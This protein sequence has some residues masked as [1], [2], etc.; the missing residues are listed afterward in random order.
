[1]KDGTEHCRI[2]F[3]YDIHRLSEQRKLMLGG[4][5]V[6]AQK[7]EVGHS[8]ADV[9]LHAIIDALLGAMSADDIGAHFPP[10]DNAWKNI[11]STVL[12]EHTV[13]LLKK[14]GYGCINIDATVLLEKPKLRPHIR[15]IRENIARVIGM[16]PERVSVK[17]K[18]K[19]G[20]D[21]VGEGIAIE[22][23]AVA[24]LTIEGEDE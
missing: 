21:A 17:A 12:L 1:M 9:L 7:G 14:N 10:S 5:E 23:Y 19:E 18:T 13:R 4:I 2:G 20:L 8:D 3:G 15:A 6:P 16:T 22:A 24:L 11:P